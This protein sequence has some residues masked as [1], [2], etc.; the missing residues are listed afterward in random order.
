MKCYILAGPRSYRIGPIY[1]LSDFVI[2]LLLL[3]WYCKGVELE[4]KSNKKFELMLARR[5]K[6]YS[7]SG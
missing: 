1:F 7:S 6:A 4:C 5:A 2:N 3:G